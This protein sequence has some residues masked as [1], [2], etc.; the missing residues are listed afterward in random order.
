MK[1]TSIYLSADDDARLERIAR[2]EGRSRA[3]VIRTAITAYEAEVVPDREFECAGIGRG[4]GDSAADL[5]EETLLEGF[6]E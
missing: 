4:P 1:K 5:T 2:S 3:D 6:G